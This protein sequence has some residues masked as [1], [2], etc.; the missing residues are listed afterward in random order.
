[1]LTRNI[2]LILSLLSIPFGL[3]LIV[4][5]YG[6]ISDSEYVLEELS[7]GFLLSLIWTIVGGSIFYQW[8]LWFT[9]HMLSFVPTYKLEQFIFNC[10]LLFI[11]ATFLIGGLIF[12]SANPLYLNLCEC[13]EG[14]YGPDCLPCPQMNGE[15]CNGHGTCSDFLL[16]TGDCDCD[17]GYEGIS[18][19]L[20]SVRFMKDEDEQ[21]CICERVL[22]GESCTESA[23]G[24]NTTFYPYVFCIRGWLQTGYEPTPK[25]RFWSLPSI[26]PVCGACE[27]F[28]AGHPEVECKQCLGRLPEIKWYPDGTCSNPHYNGLKTDCEAIGI[29]TNATEAGQTAAKGN[30]TA[31]TNQGDCV[32][33]TDCG[34]GFNEPCEWKT[35][36]EYNDNPS[37][38]DPDP[39][40]VTEELCLEGNGNYPLSEEKVCNGHG[41]CWDN[42]NYDKKVFR[43]T[44]TDCMPGIPEGGLINQCTPTWNICEKDTDCPGTFNC[45]GRCLSIY[46]FPKGPTESWAGEFNGK[47]CRSNDECNFLGNPYIGTIL[48]AGWD[49]EG[50]CAQYSCCAEAA[51][52]NYSCYNCRDNDIYDPF[53]NF[54]SNG[55]ISMGRMPPACDD[56]PGWDNDLDVNGQTICNGKGTC[57][58]LVDAQDNYVEMGC[59]CTTDIETGQKWVGPFCEC[60]KTAAPETTIVKIINTPLTNIWINGTVNYTTFYGPLSDRINDH[61]IDISKLLDKRDLAGGDNPSLSSC[62]TNGVCDS[63]KEDCTAEDFETCTEQENIIEFVDAMKEQLDYTKMYELDFKL[64]ECDFPFDDGMYHITEIENNKYKLTNRTSRHEDFIGVKDACDFRPCNY[65]D[66]CVADLNNIME[67]HCTMNLTRRFLEFGELKMRKY[68]LIE[69]FTGEL[70]YVYDY[71]IDNTDFPD[72]SVSLEECKQYGVDNS[73]ELHDSLKGECTYSIDILTGNPVTSTHEDERKTNKLLCEAPASVWNEVCL[74]DDDNYKVIDIIDNSACETA[75][76]LWSTYCSNS[77]YTSSVSCKNQGEWQVTEYNRDDNP[78]G[79]FTQVQSNGGPN[80]IYFNT[81]GEVGISENSKCQSE[82]HNSYCVQKVK[83]A[84]KT[85]CTVPASITDMIQTFLDNPNVPNDS[86]KNDEMCDTSI[87]KALTFFDT[88][89]TYTPT[90]AKEACTGQKTNAGLL[91]NVPNLDVYCDYMELIDSP[92]IFM[93]DLFT[94]KLEKVWNQDIMDYEDVNFGYLDFTPELIDQLLETYI[95]FPD[96]DILGEIFKLMEIT[97]YDDMYNCMGANNMRDVHL[98]GDKPLDM[99]KRYSIKEY[100]YTCT[101]TTKDL[102]YFRRNCTGMVMN[103]LFETEREPSIEVGDEIIVL[104]PDTLEP[105]NKNQFIIKEQI[106][107]GD[108]DIFIT[109]YYDTFTEDFCLIPQNTEYLGENICNIAENKAGFPYDSGVQSVGDAMEKCNNIELLNGEDKVGNCKYTPP[110]LVDFSTFTQG[111]ICDNCN[112]PGRIMKKEVPGS[113]ICQKCVQG[114]YLPP[115]IPDINSDTEFWNS[116]WSVQ[117]IKGKCQACP[118]VEPDKGTGLGACNFKR[119]LGACIYADAVD[120]R[121]ISEAETKEDFI[122][123][124]EN[125]GKCSCTTRLDDEPRIAAMGYNCDEAPHNFYKYSLGRDWTIL[126]CPRTLPLGLSV[127]IDSSPSYIWNHIGPDGTPRQSCTQSCGGKPIVMTMCVDDKVPVDDT[128][129]QGKWNFLTPDTDVSE[130][131]DWSVIEKVIEVQKINIEGTD[132]NGTFRIRIGESSSDPITPNIDVLNENVYTMMLELNNLHYDYGE[133]RVNIRN[134]FISYEKVDTKHSWTVTFNGNHGNIPEITLITSGLTGTNIITSVEEVTPGVSVFDK[135]GTCYCNRNNLAAEPTL[136]EY[137][138]YRSFSGL[139]VKSKVKTIID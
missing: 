79:C 139:C 125:I 38:S 24:F 77:N 85:G 64:Y 110:F 50:E 101:I 32:G 123:R 3:I 118:G 28:Y 89:S 52:G 8:L 133:G 136:Y 113:E 65:D 49:T 22:R 14:F 2:F 37:C 120:K 62:L 99:I 46:S 73:I 67:A 106:K 88:E 115:I 21:S 4:I 130:G 87:N 117:T 44:G 23:P 6:K 90:G 33:K 108:H 30:G 129:F 61:Y 15:I 78:K 86:V 97:I 20:C 60:L 112:I 134:V 75:G 19:Q 135:K 84:Y 128:D 82:E 95:N 137:H 132:L 119:G 58:P 80:R 59:A 103:L 107:K 11:S 7:H 39:L 42:D 121:K 17:I 111:Y 138:Y 104:T 18:C 26:W 76:H 29:C 16:G 98:N 69:L 10:G 53:G 71:N 27:P 131:G 127:C 124:L 70:P 81:R 35:T 96:N 102:D 114:W 31:H 126:S 93:L 41:L 56:C 92:A 12:M 40:K 48:P 13:D 36:E 43:C 83:G 66:E 57:N 25:N 55:P 116:D 45:A 94:Y 63:N 122:K 54:V 68:D 1:M 5:G 91:N 74:D 72:L 47:T 100:P 109:E 105:L 34:L 9:A 51:R